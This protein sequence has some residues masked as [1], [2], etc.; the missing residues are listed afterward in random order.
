[1]SNDQPPPRRPHPLD[2]A[3]TMTMQRLRRAGYSETELD[4]GSAIFGT[5]MMNVELNSKLHDIHGGKV[6]AVIV[7]LCNAMDSAANQSAAKILGHTSQQSK[8]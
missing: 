1:M 8:N 7:A 6:I 3:L 2:D 4:C 5:M